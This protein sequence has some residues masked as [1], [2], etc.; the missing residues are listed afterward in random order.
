MAFSWR[1][2]S[3]PRLDGGYVN[4][5]VI[6]ILKINVKLI[7]QFTAHLQKILHKL[8]NFDIDYLVYTLIAFLCKACQEIVCHVIEKSS[9]LT[10]M[11]LNCTIQ[12]KRDATVT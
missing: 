2:D 11:S 1:A 6:S 10:L 8:H 5:L 7:H 9:K 4:F 12:K 3:G